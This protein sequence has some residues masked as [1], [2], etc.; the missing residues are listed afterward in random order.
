ME[1]Y[2]LTGDWDYVLKVMAADFR[3]FQAFLVDRLTTLRE[4]QNLKSTI[5]LKSVKQTT[6][7]I[8]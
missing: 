1:C 3:D 2:Q 8:I 4:V 7:L 5:V 6:S